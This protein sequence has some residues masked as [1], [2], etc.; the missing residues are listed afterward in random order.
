[1][2]DY[3]RTHT[4]S[5]LDKAN[6]HLR[7]PHLPATILKNCKLASKG[8]KMLWFWVFSFSNFCVRINWQLKRLEGV[9]Q[10]LFQA[11]LKILNSIPPVIH[12]RNEWVGFEPTKIQ[13]IYFHISGRKANWHTF[14]DTLMH[15][16]EANTNK[17]HLTTKSYHKIFNLSWK[18]VC[19]NIF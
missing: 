9:C 19:E 16:R 12:N 5:N 10:A 7:S 18:K 17:I 4:V 13:L 6:I 8:A 1:M 15:R 2:L 3:P 14:W 11:K